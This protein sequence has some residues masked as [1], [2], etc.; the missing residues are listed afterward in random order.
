VAKKQ[1]QP[2]VETPQARQVSV[3]S[4]KPHPRNY[5]DHP[6]DQVAH[7]A[8]SMK[9]HG[10]Y[11]N[12]VI[13]KD[14]TILAGHGVVEAAKSLGMESIK[15]VRLDLDPDSP[16]ALK[17]L[18]ADNET[19]RFA[20]VDDRALTELLKD[21]REF[22]EFGLEG[23]GFDEMMLANLVMVTRPS[24]EVRDHDEA[25]EWL[26]LPDYEPMSK[27]LKYTISFET[28]EDRERFAKATG[29]RIGKPESP[30]WSANWPEKPRD[31]LKSVIVEG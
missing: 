24:S 29:L 7:I 10:V 11:R 23:T 6:E 26:G 17:L 13:A 28:N 9:Q 14:G 2:E 3:D 25:A 27:G 30:T 31:D 19:S 4:L 18:A 15:A 1:R 20:V 5:R 8:A 22:D 16:Q 21:V 12:V